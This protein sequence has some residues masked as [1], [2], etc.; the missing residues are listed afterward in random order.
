MKKLKAYFRKLGIPIIVYTDSDLANPESIF[1]EIEQ[2]L[3]PSKI[4]K[5]PELCSNRTNLLKSYGYGF[6]CLKL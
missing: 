5:K 1:S 4:Q 6:F 2:Y 3:T